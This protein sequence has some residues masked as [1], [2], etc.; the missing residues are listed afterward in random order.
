MAGPTLGTY[1]RNLRQAMAAGALAAC[2]DRELVSRL[3]AGPD[4][5]A[6]RA[7]LDRH[8]LM[9][10]RVCRRVLSDPAD[11][12]D[13][14]Q[15]TFLVL[16]RRAGS[17]R[18]HS[19]I[20]S[21]LHGVAHRTAL[22]LRTEGA[23]RK[24]RESH[25]A[26]SVDHPTT[27]ETPWGEV[28][29]AL[30]A[31]LGRLPAASRAALVLC[32][33][34]GRTQEEAAAELGLSKRTVQRHL[35]RGRELLGRRLARRGVIPAAALAARLVS[36][37][38]AG[39]AVPRALLGRTAASAGITAGRAAPVGVLP[40]R[41]AALA[42]GV[43]KAMTLA[44]CKIAAAVVVCGLVLGAG[45]QQ[46][47]PI[48]AA[49]QEPTPKTAARPAVPDIEPV[50]AG[51]VFDPA[52]QKQL[53]LSE[54]QMNRLTAARDKGGAKAADQAKRVTEIDKRLQEL[55]AEIERLHNDRATAQGAVEKAQTDS[56]KAALPDVLSRDAVGELRRI[57]IQRMNLADALLDARIRTRL[58]L[59][60][61]QVKKIQELSE[62][63][64]KWS[65]QRA[66]TLY[67]PHVEFTQSMVNL[68][69]NQLLSVYLGLNEPDRAELLK[70]LTP[71]QVETLERLSGMKFEKK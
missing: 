67:T 51:L 24:K 48:P 43:T 56:V 4:D 59:N 47:G 57:T 9:V 61:E 27:D 66:A 6:F 49:A 36:D 21:W 62:K 39:A 50:D 23:R 12:E 70:V 55:Q 60:D 41:V 53:K 34:E 52:V 10:L 18:R 33:L 54:N 29:T 63:G 25:A 35:D 69:E 42:D 45:V 44:K 19:S 5:G 28:R 26:R 15:A 31:E 71:K 14:F 1:L 30:D 3:R 7:L 64:Q 16:A 20:A 22:K 37:C 8:G 11:V 68:K 32:Y 38:S 2:P 46:F 58:D 13:A 40:P 65:F 17:I